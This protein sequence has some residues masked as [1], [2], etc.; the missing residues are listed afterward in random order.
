MNGTACCWE[1]LRRAATSSGKRLRQTIHG[2]EAIGI[3]A[4]VT[5]HRKIA[6]RPV[7]E[8]FGH[9]V[10]VNNAGTNILLN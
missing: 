8:K 6:G 2:T 4:D 10:L 7:T 1:S 5:Q 3:Q 9:D